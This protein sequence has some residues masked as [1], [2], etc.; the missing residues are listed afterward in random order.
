MRI[1]KP[2]IETRGSLK[3]CLNFENVCLAD[4]MSDT[5]G[6]GCCDGSCSGAD[7]RLNGCISVG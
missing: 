2:H 1:A 3:A 6:Y 7:G 5:D 4:S